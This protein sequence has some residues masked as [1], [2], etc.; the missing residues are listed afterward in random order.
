MGLETLKG[1]LGVPLPV[2]P[3]YLLCSTLGF[4][5]IITHKYPLYGAYIGISHRGTLVGV[6]PTI[7]RNAHPNVGCIFCASDCF[8]VRFM[9]VFGASKKYYAPA[10]ERV[11]PKHHPIEKEHHLNQTSMTGWVR[12][13]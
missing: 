9:E 7:P 10:N 2:Y 8:F 11:E 5:G 1:Q 3:W 4:L 13:V 6:H 12:L